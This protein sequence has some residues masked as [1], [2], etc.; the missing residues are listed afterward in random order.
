MKNLVE[1]ESFVGILRQT[2]NDF[3]VGIHRVRPACVEASNYD[4]VKPWIAVDWNPERM[5]D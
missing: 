3:E 1:F 2:L 5:D 4:T